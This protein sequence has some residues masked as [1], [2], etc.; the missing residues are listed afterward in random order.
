MDDAWKVEKKICLKS[1][2][3]KSYCSSSANRDKVTHHFDRCNDYFPS[4]TDKRRRRSHQ[5]HS[6]DPTKHYECDFTLGHCE[7]SDRNHGVNCYERSSQLND[8]PSSTIEPFPPMHQ[9]TWSQERRGIGHNTKHSRHHTRH[10]TDD[11]CG[12]KKRMSSSSSEDCRDGYH[13][14]YKRYHWE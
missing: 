6:Q 10:F 13:H 7:V 5:H 1:W 8:H 4:S 11:V 9:T 14:R 12:N 3:E 2:R